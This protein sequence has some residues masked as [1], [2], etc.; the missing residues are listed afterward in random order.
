VVTG[1]PA[2]VSGFGERDEVARVQRPG[3]EGVPRRRG[4][5]QSHS[6]G[7]TAASTST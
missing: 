4:P 2:E 5:R 1:E 7:S 6:I 3:F